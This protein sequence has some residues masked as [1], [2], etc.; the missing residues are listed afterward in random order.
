MEKKEYSEK[1]KINY[2]GLEV[3]RKDLSALCHSFIDQA[4]AQYAYHAISC[5]HMAHNGQKG[6]QVSL[7]ARTSHPK[8]R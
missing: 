2:V 8:T 1:E 5:Q 7:L 4:L 3:L 6:I